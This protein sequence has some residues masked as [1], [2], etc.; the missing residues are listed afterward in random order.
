MRTEPECVACIRR[1]ALSAARNAAGPDARAQTIL[2][3]EVSHLPVWDELPDH[4]TP[5]EALEA[6]LAWIRDRTGVWDPFRESKRREVEGAK[7]ALP[8]VEETLRRS[9]R[10]FETLLRI[11][12]IGNALDRMVHPNG[13]PA[14]EQAIWETLERPVQGGG[15]DEAARWLEGARRI[16][17]LADN[18]GEAVLD[19]AAISALRERTGAEVTYVVRSEPALNDVTETEAGWIGLD[20]VAAVVPNGIRGPLPGTILRRCSPDVRKRIREADVVVSKGGGNLD[21]VDEYGCLGRPTVFLFQAKCAVHERWLNLTPG[22][23]TVLVRLAPP[24][25]PER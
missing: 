14:V 25:P 22:Y 7:R 5:P 1:V 24:T 8:K 19:R 23:P 11:W 10:P 21:T 15:L 18:A 16:V 2:A 3:A 9:A 13:T 17:C 4:R 20:Q 12:C 6:V